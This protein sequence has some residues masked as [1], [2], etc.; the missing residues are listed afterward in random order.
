MI[1]SAATRLQVLRWLLSH[2]HGQAM[3]TLCACRN[4]FSWV[5]NRCTFDHFCVLWFSSSVV[6]PENLWARLVWEPIM[7]FETV[8]DLD[9]VRVTSFE[10]RRSATNICKKG[11]VWPQFNDPKSGG[12]VVGQKGSLIMANTAN[13][14][15]AEE[16]GQD[17]L[18]EQSSMA[19]VEKENEWKELERAKVLTSLV[20]TW[21]VWCTLMTWMMS[22][23][24]S[25]WMAAGVG[26]SHQLRGTHREGGYPWNSQGHGE[27][28]QTSLM[29]I[30]RNRNSTEHLRL[31]YLPMTVG[32][33]V[34]GE[35]ISFPTSLCGILVFCSLSAASS[36]A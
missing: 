23:C 13:G 15:A 19:G 5:E 18:Q 31:Q 32:E 4:P 6:C 27:H 1:A 2:A 36:S 22:H 35:W 8:T 7:N 9:D 11:M 16:E 17:R 34:N 21:R 28:T 33:W 20:R 25:P 3:F 26:A 10:L 14:F 12:A 30:E 24:W 29:R